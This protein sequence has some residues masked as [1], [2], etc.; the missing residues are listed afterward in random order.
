MEMKFRTDTFFFNSEKTYF[1]TSETFALMLFTIQKLI[2][3]IN[4]FQLENVN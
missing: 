2:L 3:N 4:Y 1:N